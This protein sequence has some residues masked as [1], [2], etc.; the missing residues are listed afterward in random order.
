MVLLSCMVFFRMKEL[1][2]EV[3]V[4]EQKE[5]PTVEWKV[6]EVQVQVV[7]GQLQDFQ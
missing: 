6:L 4:K 7:T 3:Q 2:Q 1:G 5:G